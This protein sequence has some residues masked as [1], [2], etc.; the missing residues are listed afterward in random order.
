MDNTTEIIEE[1]IVTE[2]IIIRFFPSNK[3]YPDHIKEIDRRIRISTRNGNSSQITWNEWLLVAHALLGII[4]MPNE[5]KKRLKEIET[6]I[7]VYKP[8]E[9][10]SIIWDY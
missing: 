2:N 8:D 5:L 10:Q 3:D 6:L 9:K 7:R 1:R 4:A